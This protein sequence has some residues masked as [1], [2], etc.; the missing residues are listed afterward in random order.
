MTTAVLFTPAEL[1][2]IPLKNR[3]V[4]AP[5]T[6]SRADTNGIPAPFAAKYY[7][8]RASAGLV[9]AEMTQITLEGQGY[10]R[11][12]GIYAPAHIEGWRPITK[13]VHDAGGKIVLQ[14]GHVGRVA[15]KLNRAQPADIVSASAIKAPGQMYTDQKQ[16]VDY[17]TPRALETG[18]IARLSS[19]YAT[20]AA[21][22]ITAG[23][24]GV[25][26][27]SANGYLPHQFLSTNVNQRTDRY[28]GSIANRIRM[29]LEA[30]TAITSSIGA[31]RVGIRVSP[32]HTFGGIEET[33]MPELYAAY[34]AELDKLKLA[35]LHVMRPFMNKI[36]IDPIAMARKS[37]QG[38][39]I[40]AGGYTG[41]TAAS[42]IS[43]GKAQAVAFG[44][45]Y[46]ANPDLV[47]RIKSGAPLAQPDQSTFYTPG[48]KGYADYPTL[49]A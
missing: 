13:A 48:E 45:L 8:Q 37:Y 33:D 21:N 9:V 49:A 40:A 25:E 43:S 6:R 26:L 20:A 22:A 3:F 12:P 23:F 34:F 46:I 35:Y 38:N 18:E 14:L 32:G 29:P 1:G 39:I 5:L 44:Q 24:D 41:E 31:D 7:A 11:T 16:M 36:E 4:M 30:L 19:E 42:E 15:S 27:H 28:G 2:A 47:A 10:A 17:D